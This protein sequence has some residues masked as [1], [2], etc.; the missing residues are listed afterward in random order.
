VCGTRKK[1]GEVQCDADK[2]RDPTCVGHD[3]VTASAAVYVCP[4][5]C[6]SISQ[7]VCLSA[8]LFL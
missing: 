6:L 2:C 5:A 1:N 4:S 7:S 8:H 3:S